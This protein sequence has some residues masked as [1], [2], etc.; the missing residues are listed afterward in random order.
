MAEVGEQQSQCIPS[1]TSGSVPSLASEE[2]RAVR[3][4]ARREG[5]RPGRDSAG[6]QGQRTWTPPPGVQSEGTQSQG[7]SEHAISSTS[8]QDCLGLPPGTQ[9]SSPRPGPA[10]L[11]SGKSG[12]WESV[13]RKSKNCE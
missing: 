3:G 9:L 7:P 2:R 10:S 1:R 12:K 11:A 8:L 13:K 6:R 4:E 5:G